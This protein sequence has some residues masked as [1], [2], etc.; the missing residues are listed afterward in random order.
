MERIMEILKSIILGIIQG[1]TEFLPVSSSGHLLIFESLLGFSGGGMFYNVLLH[2]A[3]LL[4]VFIVFWKD[5]VNIIK[6]PFGKE[7][8]QIVIATIPTVILALVVN[9][10]FDDYAL[11]VFVGFGFLISSVVILVTSILQHKNKGLLGGD[12]T[13]RKAF[14]IGVVQGLAVFPGISRSGS[15]ICAGLVQK[16]DR[17]KSASFSFIISIPVI[18]G[19]MVFEIADGIKY[20]FGNVQA[21]PCILGFV[22]AFVVAFASIVLMMKI[23]RRGN[24]WGFSIYLF[25]LSVFVLLNQFVFGW[26]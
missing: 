5:I 23:V 24:W 16:V 20:G 15:T 2:V 19:G 12:L 21:L 13:N 11:K 14:I 17:E 4:A 6:H 22:S 1:I 3:S 18:I 8:R 10:L 25:L 26:F 9:Y 7:M